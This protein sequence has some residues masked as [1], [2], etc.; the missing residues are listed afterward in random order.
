MISPFGSHQAGVATAQQQYMT[1]VAADLTV[2]DAVLLRR[3]LVDVSDTVVAI[4]RG[5]DTPPSPMYPEKAETPTDYATGLPP[6]GLTVTAGIGP[7]VFE[8]SGVTR[9]PPRRLRPLPDFAGDH[10]DPRWGGGDLVFQICADDP[11][12]VSAAMRALR[13][14]MPGYAVI[15]WTQSG[16]LSSPHGGG[17]P[18]NMFGQKDGTSNPRN[19]T[20]EFDDVVWALPDEP[21][22][23]RGGTYLVFRKI[24]MKTANWDLTARSEQDAVMGRHRADGSPLT[25]KAEFD[26]PDL[27][28]AKADGTL[29]IA[30]DAHIRRAHGF[31]M[32]RRSYNY[33]YGFLTAMAGGSPD[34][35]EHPENHPHAPGTKEH[36]H[37]GHGKLDVGLLFCAYG[38]DPDRQFIAAQKRLAEQDRL[39]EFI[40]H[41]GSAIFAVL[42]GFGEDGYVGD[43]LV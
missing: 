34:P 7:G 41:T 5:E 37:G 31:S 35:L 14:R 29:V 13:A 33:D 36:H 23:F 8:L 19:G 16:F 2:T 40:Q 12:V 15:R 42:P 4:T 11:Q 17:T 6:A 25:G 22:W 28:A 21:S 38:N 30:S 39:N 24:R 26:A 32:L 10:L 1:L 9:E 3:F 27:D 43:T 20:A 18:R